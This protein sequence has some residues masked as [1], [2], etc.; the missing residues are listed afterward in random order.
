MNAGY[1]Y[2]TDW[3]IWKNNSIVITIKLFLFLLFAFIVYSQ[4]IRHENLSDI[5]ISFKQQIQEGKIIYLIFVFLLLPLNWGLEVFKWKFLVNHVQKMTWRGASLGVFYGV[6]LSL[7]TPARIGELGGRIININPENRAK[8]LLAMFLG[9]VGQMIVIISFGLWALG[10]YLAI[11][12][13]IN[14]WILV[15]ILGVAVIPLLLLP[16]AY[17]QIDRITDW[18]SS[19]QWSKKFQKLIDL[20]HS[21]SQKDYFIIL[22]YSALRFFVYASQGV[23]LFKYFDIPTDW[24]VT[25]VHVFLA[26]LGQTLFPIPAFLDIPARSSI[27]IEIW[28]YNDINH[29]IVVACPF[30]L[31]IINVCLPA[32]FGMILITLYKRTK[33]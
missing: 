32:T 26:Y 20:I 15:T 6:A 5:Y 7:F 18:I 9:S 12:T 10:Y 25:Y 13:A 8:G 27:N 3:N 1:K 11:H 30:I 22:G 33:T 24:L 16:F 19:F 29:L 2:V 23:F 21:F 17:S 4:I 28:K 31:W 14:H